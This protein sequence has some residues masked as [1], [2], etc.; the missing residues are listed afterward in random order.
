MRTS[1]HDHACSRSRRDFAFAATTACAAV[2]VREAIPSHMPTHGDVTQQK[3]AEG[4]LPGG[5]PKPA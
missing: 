1:L 3:S 4:V 2:R 5:D